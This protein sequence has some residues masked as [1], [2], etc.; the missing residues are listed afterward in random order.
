MEDSN[1]GNAI[2]E[3]SLVLVVDASESCRRTTAGLVEDGGRQCIAVR[4][5]LEALSVMVESRPATIL[6][7]RESGPLDLWEFCQ[8]VRC[9]A[10][11]RAAFIVVMNSRDTLVEKAQAR[12]AGADSILM[13]PF[14][15]ADIEAVLGGNREAA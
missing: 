2:L 4:D 7:D 11:F 5:N 14:A 3:Q 10:S 12:A 8:L 15:S 6:I 9:H 13:K 1:T